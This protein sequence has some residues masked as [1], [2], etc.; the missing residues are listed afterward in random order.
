MAWHH[1]YHSLKWDKLYKKKKTVHLHN[2]CMR[3]DLVIHILNLVL[4]LQS[5]DIDYHALIT[6]S[7]YHLS[8]SIQLNTH[9]QKD[10]YCLLGQVGNLKM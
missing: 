10:S 6:N 2:I 5:L 9:C 3:T 4:L 1:S 8:F 7:P